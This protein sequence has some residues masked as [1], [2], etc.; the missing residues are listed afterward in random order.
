[1][2]KRHVWEGRSG[3]STHRETGSMRRGREGIGRQLQ[4]TGR[5]LEKTEL[6]FGRALLWEWERLW[7][8]TKEGP[9]KGK[10]PIGSCMSFVFTLPRFPLLT[11]LPPRYIYIFY[12]PT[13]IS[14]HTAFNFSNLYQFTNK[15][16]NS[17]LKMY[18]FFIV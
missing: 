4:G 12:S 13:L 10:R 14:H 16:T 15:Y 17:S 5:P 3:I 2:Q 7:C 9:L 11:L 18:F 8:S 1:M 6:S